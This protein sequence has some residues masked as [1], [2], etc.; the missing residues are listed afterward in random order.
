[1]SLELRTIWQHSRVYGL[2]SVLNR[3][4]GF[5]LIPVLTHVLPPEQWGV[6][7]LVLVVTEVLMVL[8]MGITKTM[9]RLSFDHEDDAGRGRVAATTLAVY[10]A[11]AVLLAL[12]AWPLAVLTCE[13]LFGHQ[14]YVI[15]FVIGN[16]M[17]IFAELFEIE[18]DYLRIRKR[19][20]LFVIA[21]LSRSLLQFGLAIL[22]VVYFGYG[23]EGV[24]VGHLLAVALVSL[25]ILVMIIRQV[26]LRPSGSIAREMFRLGLPLVPAWLAKSSQE[27][28]NR[29]MLNLLGT[30]AM[31]GIYALGQRLADQLRVLLS[32]PFS[33]IWG[34]RLMEVAEH[35]DRLDEFNR[36]FVYF[37]F[38]LAGAVL[39][40]ALFAPELLMV[41]SGEAY[42]GA[43]AIVPILA[44]ERLVGVVNFHFEYGIIQRKATNLLPIINWGAILFSVGALF[45]LIPPF[46]LMGAATASLLTQIVRLSVAVALT[47]AQSEIL[48]LFPWRAYAT[49]VTLAIGGF[50]AG[51]TLAG[52]TVSLTGV[53]IKGVVL[54]L[55]ALTCFFGA[56]FTSDERRAVFAFVRKRLMPRETP[57]QP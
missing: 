44:L 36:V 42:W 18:L 47:P 57:Q 52:E 19:S 13:L 41:L 56:V 23:V 40:M 37:L 10:A 29:Y 21:T 17:L 50:A 16:Y 5:L 12:L 48:K 7:A 38:L 26:G 24:L 30:V 6:Y 49:I 39:T 27:L 1:M 45:V 53:V 2:G 8:P 43:A 25:P 31:V 33:D 51:T 22:L 9:V 14:D 34:V 11:M 54:L 46:G 32:Q 15:A 3:V 35:R 4:A 55:F 28:V 20:A